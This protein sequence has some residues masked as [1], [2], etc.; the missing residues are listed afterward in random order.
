[1]WDCNRSISCCFQISMTFRKGAFL[2][3]LCS[4]WWIKWTFHLCFCIRKKWLEAGG[5]LRILIGRGAVFLHSSLL[6][7]CEFA[8]LQILLY[9]LSGWLG[10]ANINVGIC[11]GIVCLGIM[12]LFSV[13]LLMSSTNAP[14]RQTLLGRTIAEVRSGGGCEWEVHLTIS[15]FY[16]CKMLEHLS[17]PLCSMTPLILREQS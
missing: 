17:G 9:L 13:K 14:H 12:H 3:G 7:F 5:G 2:K 8:L 10:K 16:L 1:M 6:L 15:S 11:L 4:Q